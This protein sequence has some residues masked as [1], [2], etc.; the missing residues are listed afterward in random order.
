MVVRNESCT[1][2]MVVG[3][4][5]DADKMILRRKK[6]LGEGGKSKQIYG[7]MKD[8]AMT[9]SSYLSRLENVGICPSRIDLFYSADAFHDTL[10]LMGSA[11][12][13]AIAYK[14]L[15]K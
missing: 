4:G 1:R 5:S 11:A 3:Q 10:T 13:S 12:F 8:Y 14:V 9:G 7:Y 15:T 2:Y 6:T